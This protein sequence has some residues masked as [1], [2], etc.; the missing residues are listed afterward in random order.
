MLAYNRACSSGEVDNPASGKVVE[1]KSKKPA[2][3]V[4]VP[5]PVRDDG[6]NKTFK[7]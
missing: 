6:I 4:G 3:C 7:K 2:R 1:T 5:D